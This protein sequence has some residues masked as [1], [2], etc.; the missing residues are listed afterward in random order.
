M[1]FFVKILDRATADSDEI[2]LWI[3]K[4]SRQGA[5]H[6]H[7]AFLAA[8]ASLADD[9]QQHPI[10]P[11]LLSFPEEVREL[12]FKTRRG[13]RYRL[14]FVIVGKEVRVVSVRGYGEPPVTIADLT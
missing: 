6:W 2:Y 4:R 13:R 5:W 7:E 11:E 8:A 3:A 10:A 9:A 12:H 1:K 14:L